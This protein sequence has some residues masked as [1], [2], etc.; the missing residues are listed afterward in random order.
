MARPFRELTKNFS[1]E[2]KAKIKK[3]TELL[4]MEYELIS[5]LR[6]D[7]DFTQ[8]ELADI[9]DI[10]QAAISKLESQDDVLIGTLEKYIKALGGELEIKAKF[11]DKEVTLT[12][13]TDNSDKEEA[14]VY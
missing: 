7:Q 13:F 6:K 1:P 2:R 5:Q 3:G 14:R 12:Q 11:P 8:K 9:L 4:L 10:R